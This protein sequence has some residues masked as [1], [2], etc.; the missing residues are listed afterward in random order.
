MKVELYTPVCMY[1]CTYVHCMWKWSSCQYIQFLG[2]WNSSCKH[3]HLCDF[4]LPRYRFSRWN[5]SINGGRCYVFLHKEPI[6]LRNPTNTEF[7]SHFQKATKCTSVVS[8]VIRAVSE[9]MQTEKERMLGKF[10]FLECCNVYAL[11]SASPSCT[12]FCALHKIQVLIL[13]ATTL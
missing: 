5:I 9:K 8:H 1:E 12:V 4:C 11:Q 2:K 7:C 10:L 6:N 13:H 3:F